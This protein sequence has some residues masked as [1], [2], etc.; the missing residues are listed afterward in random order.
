M[1]IAILNQPQDPMAAGEEQ[2]GSVAI[3]NWE[4]AKRLARRHQ[5]VIYAPRGDGRALRES[6]GGIEIRRI[7]FA[8]K[9]LH[10]AVQLVWGRLGAK[11]P[12]AFSGL[13]YRKYYSQVARDLHEH[14]VDVI[15][16]PVQ[17]QFA[18]L[19]KRWAPQAKFVSHMHQ[20]EM[21]QLDEAYLRRH[22]RDVDSVVTVSEFV[23]ERARARF[24]ELASRIHT[25]GNGVDVERFRP[26]AGLHASV[27]PSRLLFVGRI[28]PDKG[29][30]LLMEAFNSVAPEFPDLR[31]EI[32]GKPGMMPMDVLAVLLREDPALESVRKFYGRSLLGWLRKE[33]FG[34]RHSYV[35]YLRGQLNAAVAARVNFRGTV[36]LADLVRAYQRSDLLVLPSVWQE[37][38][39]LPVAEAMASGLAVLASDCGG[40][41]ELVD[42]GS[43]GR[44]V[45]RLDVGELTRALRA[46][47]TDAARLREM[48]K[49]GRARAER[50]L[51][52]DRSA[53]RLERV[54]LGVAAE[55]PDISSHRAAG[56]Y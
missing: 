17:F 5:V 31:L 8:A 41:P 35:E 42:D 47:L 33:V 2:R 15:H 4:L 46:M 32:V 7:R 25:I 38:Y 18:G 6:W 55:A 56:R 16:V 40:V 39:G 20:D 26:A 12:Y 43:S 27:R 24:P 10:K 30:H 1:K 29:L 36:S 37:S 19:F 11:V 13:Y 9:P 21:A 22:M 14:P 54:Y 51:T 48:G 45:P 34:Q 3:V 50:L 52:W 28:A 23:S 53:E 49:A 44:L